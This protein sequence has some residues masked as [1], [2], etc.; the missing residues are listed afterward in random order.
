MLKSLIGLPSA[1]TAALFSSNCEAKSATIFG[2]HDRRGN[3]TVREAVNITVVDLN[4]S[5]ANT[6]ACLCS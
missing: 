6:Q 1:A 2:C 5:V 4:D 3:I